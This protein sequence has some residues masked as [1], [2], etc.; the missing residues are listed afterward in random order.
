MPH[1][2]GMLF[3]IK[4]LRE[5]LTGWFT[6]LNFHFFGDRMAEWSGDP[7]FLPAI[8]R[9]LVRFPSPSGH[10]TLPTTGASVNVFVAWTENCMHA[11]A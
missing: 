4:A 7:V 1:A 8:C 9:L 2:N 3:V 6:V 10:A 5:F 11:G